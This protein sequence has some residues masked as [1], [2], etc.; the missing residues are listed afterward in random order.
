MNTNTCG[1]NIATV[2]QEKVYI[3]EEDVCGQLKLP[4]TNGSECV[5]LIDAVDFSSQ[6]EL[7]PDR[8]LRPIRSR[9]LPMLGRV[10]AGEYTLKTYVKPSGNKGQP[11]Q[12]GRLLKLA[13]GKETIT[14]GQKVEYTLTNEPK[15]FSLWINLGHTVYAFSGATV[16]EIRFTGAGDKEAEYTFSGNAMKLYRATVSKSNDVKTDSNEIHVLNPEYFTP[17]MPIYIINNTNNNK[18]GLDNPFI[19]VDIIFDVENGTN[20]KLILDRNVGITSNDATIMPWLPQSC[21]DYGYPQFGKYGITTLNNQPFIITNWNIMFKNNIKYYEN[22]KNGVPFAT[23][24]A[25]IKPREI[26]IEV[27]AYFRPEF[28]SFYY[29]HFTL[30]RDELILPVGE[31]EGQIVEWKFKEVIWE[32]PNY[33]GNEEVNIRLKGQAITTT[34]GNDELVV[35]Y[36]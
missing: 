6:S 33:T 29:K 30:S 31:N 36:R 1:L 27:E 15:S 13:L 11:P 10:R 22:E 34:L 18:V 14:A 28:A 19:I 35:I 25:V 9:K 17:E 2:I 4:N 26:D 20:H 32:T 21:A 5:L 3:V 24:Y 12:E 16:N 23:N 7:L 8:Q